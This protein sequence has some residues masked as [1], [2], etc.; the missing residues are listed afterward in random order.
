LE[1]KQLEQ[2]A[3]YYWVPTD[4]GECFA[5]DARALRLCPAKLLSRHFLCPQA[6][7]CDLISPSWRSRLTTLCSISR[8][9]P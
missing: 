5:D 3:P 9:M 4:R 8:V 7:D 6:D 1:I 2:R